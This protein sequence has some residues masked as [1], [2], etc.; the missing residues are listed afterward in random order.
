M[1]KKQR[2]DR[3]ML[4]QRKKMYEEYVLKNDVILDRE[5]INF[6]DVNYSFIFKGEEMPKVP[7]ESRKK[8]F[9]DGS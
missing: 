3:E 7:P 8:R 5:E 2:L 1:G 4:K 9:S 6:I